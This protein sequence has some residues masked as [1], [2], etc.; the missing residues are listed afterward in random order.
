MTVWE[1]K[2]AV[3]RR[4]GMMQ[5][6]RAGNPGEGRF[7]FSEDLGLANDLSGL[8]GFVCQSNLSS[9]FH[10]LC[11]LRDGRFAIMLLLTPFF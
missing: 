5:M 2:S 7:F 4:L 1:F 6:A 3:S 11:C 9:F 10:Y 8:V